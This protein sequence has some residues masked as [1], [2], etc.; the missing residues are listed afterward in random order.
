M[1]VWILSA[2][3]PDWKQLTKTD[4]T[5]SHMQNYGDEARNVALVL[6][7]FFFQMLST[8]FI[9]FLSLRQN[10]SSISLFEAERCV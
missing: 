1:E 5:Q 4:P 2:L 3:I 8:L 9:V 10:M 7:D 6:R